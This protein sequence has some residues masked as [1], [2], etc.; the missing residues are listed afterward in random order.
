MHKTDRIYHYS[1]NPLCL[2]FFL[3]MT[4]FMFVGVWFHLASLGY[5]S[6]LNA[7]VCS[8]IMF[9]IPLVL[10]LR[11]P[12]GERLMINS[13]PG[14]I[15]RL[16]NPFVEQTRI[17]TT[18]IFK[19]DVEPRT[20]MLG[21]RAIVVHTHL[22][23]YRIYPAFVRSNWARSRVPEEELISALKAVKHGMPGL[24]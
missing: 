23:N 1:V 14:T 6:T 2:G 12:R 4:G 7:R 16:F 10:A 19:V 5:D 8:T 20:S 18:D 11:Q 21:L 22:W 24:F 17:P 3:V 15:P 9:G 13:A